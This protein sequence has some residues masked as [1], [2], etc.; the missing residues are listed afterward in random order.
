MSSAPRVDVVTPLS[1]GSYLRDTGTTGSLKVVV[2]L[3]WKPPEPWRPC[4]E[5]SF[6]QRQAEKDTK[7]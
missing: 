5:V 6:K 7:G 4:M 2:E 1:P 3:T